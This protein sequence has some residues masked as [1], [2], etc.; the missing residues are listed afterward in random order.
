MGLFYAHLT[1]FIFA[2]RARMR[3]CHAVT[4]VPVKHGEVSV[5]TSLILSNQLLQGNFWITLEMGNTS[6]AS[7]SIHKPLQGQHLHAYIHS[8]IIKA[9]SKSFSSFCHGDKSLIK[10]FST[11]IFRSARLIKH[12]LYTDRSPRDFCK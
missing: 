4:L 3:K 5:K 6:S 8:I 11:I 2:P 9:T 1:F 7:E 12:C 10:G